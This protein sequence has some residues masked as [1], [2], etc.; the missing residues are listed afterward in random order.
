MSTFHLPSI[1]HFNQAARLAPVVNVLLIVLIAF[2]LA[3]F[4]WRI[5]A[6]ETAPQ[7]DQPAVTSLTGPGR[8]IDSQAIR[9][10][11]ALHL[12]G[13]VK[14]EDVAPPPVVDAPDTRL[15]LTL[16]GVLAVDSPDARAIIASPDGNENAYAVGDSL[17]GN[18][19]L[20]QIHADRVILETNGRYETLRLP[21]DE[22]IAGRTPG[23]SGPEM[24]QQ[25]AIEPGMPLREVRNSMVENP[26]NL[27]RHIRVI[28][29]SPGG[30]FNGFRLMPGPD[31]SVFS[32]LGLVPGDIVKEI[33]GVAL[34][35]V[36][37][38]GE[39][40]QEIASANVINMTI[41]RN[42]AQ[43]ALTLNMDDLLK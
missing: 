24:S 8:D 30:K 6:P 21:V 37:K 42:G 41:E 23:G 11:A 4:T 10:L 36:S 17:P 19:R 32:R 25:A 13:E 12:F 7:P 31:A 2:T 9:Q 33:N 26:G 20:R 28:P 27:L 43:Q 35:D 39:A 18:A 14:V 40:L 22:P 16:S 29:S 38:G 3:R 34:D 5:F 15:N 1:T